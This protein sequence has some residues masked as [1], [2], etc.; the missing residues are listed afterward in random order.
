MSALR[1]SLLPRLSPPHPL[2]DE[3]AGCVDRAHRYLVV[4]R[5]VLDGIDVLADRVDAD[6]DL[7]GVVAEASGQLER[8]RRRLRV[9]RSR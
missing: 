6:H 3:Q 4:G 7:D 9:D 2:G 1:S 8:A 5:E